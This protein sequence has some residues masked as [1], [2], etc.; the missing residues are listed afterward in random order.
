MAN[1]DYDRYMG[2]VLNWMV[3]HKDELYDV[4]PRG[5]SK[6]GEFPCYNLLPG[7]TC[8]VEAREHC[9]KEGCYAI[10]NAL[11]AGYDVNKSSVLKSWAR[12]TIMAIWHR[13]ELEQ[14]LNAYFDG[15]AA[16][17]FFRIHAAGDFVN[18]EYAWMW[19][20]VARQHPGTRFLAFTKAWTAAREI[21]FDELPQF[22]LVLSAWT[23]VII[24]EDLRRRY[25]CAWC[26]DGTEDRIPEDALICPG[27]C[28]RCGMCWG[29]KD[30]C[31]DVKFSKH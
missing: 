10:K 11:R 3:E 25:R 7:L 16:P 9:M 20:R 13:A 1:Y 28:D 27:D 18:M 26:D 29:L 30:I 31:R 5:N 24:P 2:N 8:T 4:T 23:G 17:K 15:L 14:D 21:P 12:N 22:S 6:T 19:Y